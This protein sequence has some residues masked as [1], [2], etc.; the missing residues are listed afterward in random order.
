MTLT[1]RFK[2][3]PWIQVIEEPASV[4]NNAGHC[5]HPNPPL[6][7]L[8][9]SAAWAGAGDGSAYDRDKTTYVW[10]PYAMEWTWFYHDRRGAMEDV[11]NSPPTTFGPLVLTLVHALVHS[12]VHSFPPPPPR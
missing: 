8:D 7:R 12:F 4:Y 1:W 3:Q 5:E 6:I 2:E 9:T 10:S 11:R